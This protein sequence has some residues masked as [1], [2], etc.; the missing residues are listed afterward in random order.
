MAGTVRDPGRRRRRAH[1]P[2]L[3]A[4]TPLGNHAHPGERTQ[5]CPFPLPRSTRLWRSPSSTPS[6]TTRSRQ[7]KWRTGPASRAA[8]RSSSSLRSPRCAAHDATV[9]GRR[10]YRRPALKSLLAHAGLRVRRATYA[11]SFLTPA[12]AALA[13]GDRIRPARAPRGRF[14]R[15]A[16]WARRIVRAVGAR[17][18][19]AARVVEPSRRDVGPRARDPRRNE[20]GPLSQAW[21]RAPA[22]DRPFRSTTSSTHMLARSRRVPSTAGRRKNCDE[23]Y[24][25]R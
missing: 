24:T 20:R 11:Y 22:R 17:R 4:A 18:A 25:R 7:G 10:R 1:R 3:R 6:P 13:L 19:H 2:A 8:R 12:A 5:R 21:A 9:H 23:P 16:P 14:R 15:R